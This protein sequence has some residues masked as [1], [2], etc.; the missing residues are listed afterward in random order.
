LSPWG[1]AALLGLIGA[2]LA[3]AVRAEATLAQ[4]HALHAQAEELADAGIRQAML[5]LAAPRPGG[6]W[7]PGSF[8]TFDLGPGRATVLVEDEDGKVDIKATPVGALATLFQI[9][10]LPP[11][12]SRAVA[13]QAGDFR[14]PDDE[15]R[16]AG[17]EAAAYRAAGLPP[18]S[19]NGPFQAVGEL[20]L[21]PS[22]DGPTYILIAAAHRSQPVASR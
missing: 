5:A 6:G 2:G 22:V 14:D 12:Q 17:A 10:G 21:L 19:R 11:G 8:R 7:D 9:A 15:P 13:D 3:F 16:P 4:H 20:L 1:L 18:G